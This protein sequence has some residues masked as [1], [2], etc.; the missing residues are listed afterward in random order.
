MSTLLLVQSTTLLSGVGVFC[1]NFGEKLGKRLS[2]ASKG[3]LL[4]FG[5]RVIQVASGATITHMA[6]HAVGHTTAASLC[7]WAVVVPIATKNFVLVANLTGNR[8]L[9]RFSMK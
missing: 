7:P 5:A 6:L 4:L 2:D 3:S 9:Q 8:K 1:G